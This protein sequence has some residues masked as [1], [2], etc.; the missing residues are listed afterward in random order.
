MK[1]L[2]LSI[3]TAT[4]VSTSIT[5]SMEMKVESIQ[6][7]KN[8]KIYSSDGMMRFEVYKNDSSQVKVVKDSQLPDNYMMPENILLTVIQDIAKDNI[9]SGNICTLYLPEDLNDFA[10]KG[11]Y[12]SKYLC[13]INQVFPKL[14]TLNIGILTGLTQDLYSHYTQLNNLNFS[15]DRL[16]PKV[17]RKGR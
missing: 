2:I 9:D 6:I 7:N 5:L 17:K 13:T 15:I 12:V 14:R 11:D 4:I 1:K 10:V 16:P 3:L 8:I